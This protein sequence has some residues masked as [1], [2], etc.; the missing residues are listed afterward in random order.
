MEN[1]IRQDTATLWRGVGLG[2]IYRQGFDWVLE[3]LSDDVN[4]AIHFTGSPIN[5]SL[6]ID[7]T[8]DI[9]FSVW[10]KIPYEFITAETVVSQAVWM[11][12]QEGGD[13]FTGGLVG[14]HIPRFEV[15][16]DWQQLVL[17][18]PA[19]DR[20]RYWASP[21]IQIMGHWGSGTRIYLNNPVLAYGKVADF[22]PEAL[23]FRSRSPLPW[24]FG[25]VTLLAVLAAMIRKSK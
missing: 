4:L 17:E 12:N 5:Q 24:V 14:R 22:P 25:G 7:A 23:K 9:F 20:E 6:P 18:I 16:G 21:N 13:A 8:L 11:W 15:T 1:L 10:A 2:K 19:I 3:A